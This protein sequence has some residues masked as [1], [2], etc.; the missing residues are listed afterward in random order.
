MLPIL[1]RLGPIE[2]PAY[3]FMMAVG[4][5]LSWFYFSSRFPEKETK[6]ILSALVSYSVLAG[7]A[8]ARLNYMIE[9]WKEIHSWGDFFSMLFSRS[10][11]TFYGGVLCGILIAYLYSRKK[12]LLT[13]AI[14][15]AGA[16]AICIGYF[17]G[18]AGCQLAG[19]GDYGTPSDLPWAMAYP[20]GTVPVFTPVHPTPVYEMLLYALIF[21]ILSNLRKRSLLEGRVFAAFLALAG[22]ERFGI[23]FLRLNPAVFWR[24]TEAQIVSV[25]LV[26]AGVYLWLRKGGVSARMN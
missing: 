20:R 18:R 17:F 8:G 26:V 4:I 15:D 1:F 10:G 9:H 19:D 2:I 13:P 16:P 23:E 21:A 25:V 5:L 24:F 6:D 22:I 7:L 3:G 14:M 11:L 12:H